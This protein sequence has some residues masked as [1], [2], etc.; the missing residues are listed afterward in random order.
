MTWPDSVGMAGAARLVALVVMVAACG[1][2]VVSSGPLPSPSGEIGL[3]ATSEPLTDPP[4]AT[5]P[6]ASP[7]GPS[8]L[9][10]P[11]LLAILPALVDGVDLRPAP[12]AALE[13]SSDRSLAASASAIAVGLA[14]T[15]SA[16][17]D[18]FASVS[19]V[20]LRPGI[21]SA[22]F[23]GQWRQSYDA[24]ACAQAGGVSSHLQQVLGARTV[25]VTLCTGG[26]RTLHAH[27]A[28]DILVSITAV[29]DRKLGDLVMTALRE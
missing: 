13:M 4:P 23:F 5:P 20:R 12:A 25:E 19:V 11:T 26:A 14:A 9:V 2:P 8:V 29:G 1:A 28:G 17:G 16:V 10:D 21:Y 6:A 18:D 15:G 22:S 24:A 3:P 7:A 27:L